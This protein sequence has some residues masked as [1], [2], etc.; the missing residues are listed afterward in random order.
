MN[1][2]V[3]QTEWQSSLEQFRLKEKE[4]MQRQDQLN[5]ER[6]RL[7]VIQI[8][9]NYEFTAADGKASLFE[10]FEGRRQL[11]V[12]HFMFAPEAESGCTGCSMA[13]DNIG[14]LAHIQARDTS[15]V[16][17]ARAPYAKLDAYKQR[18]GWDIP[19]YSSYNSDFNY[20]MGVSS[21]AGE[22]HG[23]SVF[24]REDDAIYRTYFTTMR[25][26]EYLGSNWTYLDLT[27]L[28]RQ[29]TWEDSPQNVEQSA[30]YQWWR[31]HDS[32]TGSH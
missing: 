32:Y 27:P 2:I 17:I 15:F 28:G 7:P 31:L 21:D 29:E 3:S 4:Q 11:I 30:P 8:D 6:R 18:M 26:V 25:G 1:N 24:L 22:K 19:W 9:K 23:V 16:L 14:H 12:Y 10:L 5:A 13:V 20:D